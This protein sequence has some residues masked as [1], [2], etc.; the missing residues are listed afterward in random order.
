[1]NARKAELYVERQTKD[2]L[3]KVLKLY[4]QQTAQEVRD[5]YGDRSMGTRSVTP[6]ELADRILR[7][8][9]EDKFPMVI[10][11]EQELARVEKVMIEETR[12][13]SKQGQK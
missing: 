5:E 1:M 4:P 12:K 11:L 13:L 6:D 2:R 10:E 3:F 8:Y 7:E 9:I